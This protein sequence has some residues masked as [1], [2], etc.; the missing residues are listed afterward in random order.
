MWAIR[1]KMTKKLLYAEFKRYDGLIMACVF[2]KK[3]QAEALLGMSDKKGLEIVK[4][5]VM[6]IEDV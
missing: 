1:N 6:V 4:I 5:E 2:E 3:E